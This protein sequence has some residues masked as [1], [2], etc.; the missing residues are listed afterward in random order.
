MKKIK[1]VAIERLRPAFIKIKEGLEQESRETKEMLKIYVKYTRSEATKEEMARA[2]RQFRDF[3]KTMGLGILVAL[4]FAV[5][6]IP[7]IVKW[8]E[9]IGID[10][11]PTR[12]K[13]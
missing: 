5:V 4:P 10:I 11:I 9:K 8:G 12:F 2:N 1:D 7:L 3:L 6:T 13:E